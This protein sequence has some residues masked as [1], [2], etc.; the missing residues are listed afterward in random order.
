MGNCSSNDS[1]AVAEPLPANPS[2]EGAAPNAEKAPASPAAAAPAPA[3][4]DSD[5]AWIKN[6]RIVFVLGAL[7]S[8]HVRLQAH[9]SCKEYVFDGLFF[10]AKS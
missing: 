8:M 10:L 4:A 9:L 5:K 7:P 6:V 3:A 1:V 2:T